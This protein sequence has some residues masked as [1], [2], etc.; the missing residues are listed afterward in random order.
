MTTTPTSPTSTTTATGGRREALVDRLRGGQR[1]AVVAGGQGEPW[2]EPLAALVRDFALESDVAGLVARA[3]QRLAPVAAELLRTGVDVAP[4]AWLDALAV[5]ESAEDDDAPEVPDAAALQA[6]AVSVPGILLTQLA[7]LAALQRQGLDVVATPPVACAGHS[8][9]AYVVEALAG[10][11]PADLYAHARLA[12]DNC[13]GA[14][15]F[16]RIGEWLA[17][18]A[19]TREDAHIRAYSDHVSDHP[20]LGF[21]DEAVATTPSRALKKLAPQRGWAVVDWRQKT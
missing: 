4:L 7:G 17:D 10:A 13:Y 6:P 8:Q 15:K 14:A 11:D 12:G 18:N 21:A 3:E 19:I 2:L 5:G 20:M 9:G 1:Y 16:A